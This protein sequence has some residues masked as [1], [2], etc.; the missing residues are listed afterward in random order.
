VK[1]AQ[2][3]INILYID[4]KERKKSLTIEGFLE[5]IASHFGYAILSLNPMGGINV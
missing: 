1:I 3:Y 5:N 4:Q 2:L